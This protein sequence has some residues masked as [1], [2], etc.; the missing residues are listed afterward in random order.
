MD[1][2]AFYGKTRQQEQEIAEPFPI[3][4]SHETAG[5]GKAGTWTEVA[6]SVAARFIVQGL[7]RLA[8]HEE[9]KIFRDAQAEAKRVADELLEITK[10]QFAWMANQRIQNVQAALAP[11]EAPKE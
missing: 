4:V 7:A 9:S 2:H 11:K 5:G 8:T 10:S 1:L 6:R 3:I